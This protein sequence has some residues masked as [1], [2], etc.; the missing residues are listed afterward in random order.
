MNYDILDKSNYLKGLL[1]LCR[2]DNL[3]AKEEK[4]IL[5]SIGKE[6]GFEKRFCE[7]AVQ[8]IMENEYIIDVPPKFSNKELAEKFLEDGVRLAMADKCLHLFE[9]QWLAQTA[10]INNV[11]NSKIDELF[12]KYM[13]DNYAEL[14]FVEETTKISA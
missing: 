4:E 6:L 7:N 5:V 12:K 9:L 11:D 13:A 2:K 1:L 14:S 3:V 8:E 10:E